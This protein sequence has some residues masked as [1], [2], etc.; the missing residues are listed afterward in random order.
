MKLKTLSRAAALLCA[1]LASGGV[2]AA[3]CTLSNATVNLASYNS[4]TGTL[5]AALNVGYSCTRNGNG[6]NV[7]MTINA[8]GGNNYSAPRRRMLVSGNYMSYDLLRSTTLTDYW[9]NGTIPA[10]SNPRTVVVS[11]TQF[12]AGNILVTP[13]GTSFTYYINLPASQTPVTGQTYTDTVTLTGS[14]VNANGGNTTAC[15]SFTGATITINFLYT[16]TCS[17]SQAPSS[18]DMVYTSFQTLQS[19]GVSNFGVN[20]SNGLPYTIT[21]NGAS[22]TTVNSSMLGL[23]YSLSVP[24]AGQTGTGAQQNFS[25]TG[26]I[27]ANQSGTCATSPTCSQTD[28]TNFVQINW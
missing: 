16:S 7:T 1:G 14:C 5:T 13:A 6:H 26:T 3:S 8:N 11:N 21:L 19:Q 10:A 2:W 15:T 18:L 22:S 4:A 27:P 25:V 23:N 28:T 12:G 9:G 20:C 24:S 17:I